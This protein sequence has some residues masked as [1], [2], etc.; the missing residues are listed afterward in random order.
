MEKRP[1]NDSK[2][3]LAKRFFSFFEIFLKNLSSKEVERMC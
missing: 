3:A 2:Y 1:F